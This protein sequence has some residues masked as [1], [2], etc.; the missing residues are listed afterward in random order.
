MNSAPLHHPT[1]DR[2]LAYVSGQIDFSLRLLMETHLG[3]CDVCANQVAE[4]SAPGGAALRETPKEVPIAD[5]FD[6]IEAQV[7]GL[8]AAQAFKVEGTPVPLPDRIAAMLP[9]TSN[10]R[11]KSILKSGIRYVTLLEDKAKDAAVYIVHIKAGCGFPAHT[12]LGLEQAV[13][14]AGGTKDHLCTMEAGDY[15]ENGPEL[16]HQPTALEDEDCWLLTRLEG[17]DVRFGGWR[18]L[19]QKL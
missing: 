14:L 15:E 17:G 2:L 16:T 19:L 3:V 12:H 11:W 9:K 10:L 5:F 6:R 4:F 13:I 8:S 1:E 18:G 7:N